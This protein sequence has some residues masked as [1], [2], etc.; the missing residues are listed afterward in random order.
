MAQKKLRKTEPR[1]E[2]GYQPRLPHSSWRLARATPGAA[3]AGA[4]TA[5]EFWSRLGL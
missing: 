1:P 3:E 2:R 5:S 4:P